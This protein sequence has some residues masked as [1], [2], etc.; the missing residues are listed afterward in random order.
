MN[1]ARQKHNRVVNR[2]M[3]TRKTVESE[4]ERM[5]ELRKKY[6]RGALA[7]NTVAECLNL[8]EQIRGALDDFL[9]DQEL[10]K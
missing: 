10:Y 3:R 4:L 1:S 5:L 8:F 2:L 9:S 6:A 7:E